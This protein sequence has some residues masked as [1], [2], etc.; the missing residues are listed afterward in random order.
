MQS[1]LKVKKNK[2][3]K[4]ENKM[5]KSK[6]FQARQGDVYFIEA[7]YL[8][9]DKLPKTMLENLDQ[10]TLANGEVTGHSH[11]MEGNV[12]EA[13]RENEILTLTKVGK[14]GS[15]VTH[16]EHSVINFKEGSYG[17][18]RQQEFVRGANMPVRD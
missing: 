12:L 5:K 7:S 11:V 15:K 17:A 16:Q 13:R 18:I 14:K 1:V 9:K 4:K 8:K 3:N 10:V 6:P 2:Q